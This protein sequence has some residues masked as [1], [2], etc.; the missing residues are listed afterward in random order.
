M[1]NKVS[2]VFDD[3]SEQ[4]RYKTDY[5]TQHHQELLMG[6]VLGFPAQELVKQGLGEFCHYYCINGRI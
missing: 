6:E 3:H 1:L 2:E 5:R 4:S